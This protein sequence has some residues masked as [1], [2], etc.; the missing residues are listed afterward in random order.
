MTDLGLLGPHHA[1]VVEVPVACS[2]TGA[3]I[4]VEDG[5]A[6]NIGRIPGLGLAV[7]QRIDVSTQCASQVD[8]EVLA[9]VSRQIA[10]SDND[11]RIVPLSR[12]GHTESPV[13][14]ILGTE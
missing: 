7:S 3:G 5:A 10:R 8:E 4:E 6:R 11:A 13:Q 2:D 14:D 12:Q 1:I 9:L